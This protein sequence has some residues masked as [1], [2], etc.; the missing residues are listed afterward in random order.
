M[1]EQTKELGAAAALEEE[2][3]TALQAAYS[4][5]GMTLA[6]SLYESDNIEGVAGVKY[7]ETE[8]SVSFAF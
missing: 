5:G 3:L 2:E 6:A 8:L 1:N 4:M 7:E